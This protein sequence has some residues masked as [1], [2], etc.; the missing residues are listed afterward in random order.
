MALETSKEIDIKCANTLESA[1]E[2]TDAIAKK[3][4]D[5]IGKIKADLAATA[6]SLEEA[7]IAQRESLQEAQRTLRKELST[8]AAAIHEAVKNLNDKQ[9]ATKAEL[10]LT[11]E[12]LN[13]LKEQCASEFSEMKLQA[14]ALNVH[15]QEGLAAVTRLINSLKEDHLRY[16]EKVAGHVSLLQH[17]N[18]NCEEACHVLEQERKR[19]VIDN[20]MMT[21]RMNG[22]NDWSADV[23][24]KLMRLYKYVQP[25]RCEWR[26]HKVAKKKKE[27]TTPMLLKSP[28][29]SIA[30]FKDL[31]FD[32]YP[33]GYYGLPAG[34]SCIRFYAP[35]NTHIKYECYLGTLCDGPQEWKSGEE[36]L[37]ND[38]LFHKW[39]DEV[40]HNQ[41]TIAV[42]I[43]ADLSL[44]AEGS[45]GGSLKI[46]CE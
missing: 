19:F 24:T 23:D 1:K 26:I 45:I 13:T 35:L 41:I 8:A 9:A 18:Q 39:D 30:G 21:D 38:H 28:P 22:I 3:H 27:L 12:R 6:L 42:D 43:L 44:G 29:F 31:R 2:H 16:K 25:T 37:W 10:S 20:R 34:T 17:Q 40:Q 5:K 36:S 4:R 33:N 7:K 15:S 32:W 11:V 46:D 14:Q